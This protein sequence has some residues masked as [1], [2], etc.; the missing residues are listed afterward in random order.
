MKDNAMRQRRASTRRALAKW[1]T[2]LAPRGLGH[3]ARRG[4]MLLT[5]RTAAWSVRHRAV[6]I[7]G[8]LVVGV[9]VFIAGQQLSSAD[10]PSYDAGQSGQAEQA[11]DRLGITLPTVEDVLIQAPAGSTPFAA[12]SAM[13]QA[14][15]QLVTGLAREPAVAVNIQSPLDKADRG[16]VSGDGRSVLVTFNVAG[17]A[18]DYAAKAGTSLRAV[19]AVQASH[20]GL[21]IAESGP[22]SYQATLSSVL[23][24]GFRRAEATSAPITLLILLVVFGALIAA[25]VPLILAALSVGIALSLLDIASRWVPTGSITSEVVLIVGMAVGVDYSLFYLRREREE[26]GNGATAAEALQTAAATSGHAVLVSG[27]TVIIALA[28]LF[29]VRYDI[30]DG[31]AIGTIAVVATAMTASITLLPAVLSLL[32]RRPD[33]GRIP[34]LGRRR[35]AARTSR[36][37]AFVVQRV[38]RHPAAALACG[39]IAMIALAAPS[40]GLRFGNPAN[41]LPPGT[42]VQVAADRIHAA[43][44][45]DPSALVAVTGKSADSAATRNAIAAVNARVAAENGVPRSA[46]PVVTS[47]VV[48]GGRALILTVPLRATDPDGALLTLRDQILPAT[49]GQVGALQYPVTG[50]TAATYDDAA[51]LHGGTVVVWVFVAVLSFLLLLAAFRSVS[52]AL[53]SIVLNLLSVGASY[54]LITLIFQDGRLQGVLGYTSFGGIVSWIPLFMFVLLFGLSM[55]YHVFVLTRVY[56]LRRRGASPKAAVLGGI[57][58]SAGVVTSAAVIMVAVFSIL[59]S[60]PP[61]EAKTLGLGLAAAVLIDATVVRGVLLPAALVL[62]GARWHAHSEPGSAAGTVPAVSEAGAGAPKARHSG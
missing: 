33:S 52:V 26:R 47:D 36:G 4:P 11:M 32:G 45:E 54:G 2:G 29:L 30:F 23:A 60:L 8:W 20:P 39:V 61:V 44:P 10:K 50:G 14:A 53:T 1:R 51:A 16:L 62:L 58:T 40:L 19:A 21:Y 37:W 41:D 31:I 34:V 22:A 42:A 5:R 25:A 17:S 13:R 57:S 9:C 18:A 3:R 35:V 55:D 49:L 24:S 6:V 7:L 56:E 43:F 48:A 15:Q 28:G 12:N 59:A 46:A 27:L 38:V